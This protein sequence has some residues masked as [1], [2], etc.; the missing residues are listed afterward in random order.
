MRVF[1]FPFFAILLQADHHAS[2]LH[3]LFML[4]FW[5]ILR[6]LECRGCL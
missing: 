2:S 3:G 5:P 4:V 1:G 6:H